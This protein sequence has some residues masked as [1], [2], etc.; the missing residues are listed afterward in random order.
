MA[1]GLLQLVSSG[2]Q[3]VALTYNPE[4]TF[5]KKKYRRHTNFSLEIKEIYVEQQSNYGDIISFNLP[6]NGDLI[7]RCFV[8]VT[9]PALQFSDSIIKNQSYITWK[10][11]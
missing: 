4:I 6:T 5:F 7:Y 8:Q 11:D 3:D 1:G 9:I 10:N 2:S